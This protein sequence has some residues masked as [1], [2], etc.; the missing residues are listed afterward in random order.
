MDKTI[1]ISLAYVG[2]AV[3]DGSRK[4]NSSK[5]VCSASCCV[6]SGFLHMPLLLRHILRTTSIHVAGK[7]CDSR[8][9][10]NPAC[11]QR[12]KT[13]GLSRRVAETKTMFS[14]YYGDIL[15]RQLESLKHCRSEDQTPEALS[16]PW[17]HTERHASF[18][19]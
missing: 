1:C 18:S 19:N 16:L 6:R 4:M 3:V 7:R 13:A 17:I 11:L 2:D 9:S 5:V 10:I 8:T 14:D 15:Q 12:T